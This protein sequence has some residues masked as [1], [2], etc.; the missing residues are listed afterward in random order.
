MTVSFHKFLKQEVRALGTWRKCVLFPYT[1]GLW[2]GLGGRRGCGR[3]ADPEEQGLKALTAPGGRFG[4][5][6]A[7]EDELHF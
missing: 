6:R 4:A 2:E 1:A 3:R 7:P 5:R